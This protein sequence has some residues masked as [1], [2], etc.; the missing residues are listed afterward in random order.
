MGFKPYLESDGDIFYDGDFFFH[1]EYTY[2]IVPGLNG[3]H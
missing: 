3:L 2:Q 1:L